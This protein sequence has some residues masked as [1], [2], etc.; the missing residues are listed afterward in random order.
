MVSIGWREWV[1]LPGIERAAV[2][3]KIDTGAWSNSL[4]AAEISVDTEQNPQRV[5]FRLS[6]DTEL[7]DMPLQGWRRVRDSGGHDTMRPFIRTRLEIAG[8]DHEVELCL[9]DRA[10][11]RHRLILGR[12]LLRRGFRILPE[13]ER[14]H[15]EQRTTPRR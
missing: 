9:Q 2:L 6:E 3:A 10:R 8:Q 12:R 11:M 7:L 13:K 5:R 14:I 15:P 4:H 1:G